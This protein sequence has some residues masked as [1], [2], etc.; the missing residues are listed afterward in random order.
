MELKQLEYFMTVTEEGNISAAAKKLH[1]TQPPL[2]MQM[3]HLEAELQVRLFER[4][5][6]SITLTEAGKILYER[7]KGIL[8]M[9][10]V[11][12]RELGQM[13]DETVGTLRLG[14]ISSAGVSFIK[15]TLLPFHEKYPEI[16]LDVFEGNTY[17]LL[18]ALKSKRVDVAVVRTPFPA[19]GYSCRYFKEDPMVAAGIPLYFCDIKKAK[20]SIYDMA[21]IPLIIYRRWEHILRHTF[22]KEQVPLH[23]FCVNDDARTSL[24]LASAGLGV[25]LVPAS[26]IERTEHTNMVIKTMDSPALNSSLTVIQKKGDKTTGP[27]ALFFESCYT[28]L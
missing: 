8:E 14:M 28:V 11:T 3:K 13:K 25:A 4:G 20:L 1:I 23:L 15:K 2:S 24:K 17:Q 6:R 5:A 7:A 10:T 27:S 9:A 18:E 19:E 26:A 22:E 21:D 16:R 12:T